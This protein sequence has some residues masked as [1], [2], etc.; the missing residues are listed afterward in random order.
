VRLRGLLGRLLAGLLGRLHRTVGARIACTIGARERVA[1]GAQRRLLAAD[2][3][4]G[5]LG[6]GARHLVDHGARGA[7]GVL[8]VLLCHARRLDLGV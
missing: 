4:L 2:A 6:R 1:H 3:A 7:G 8:H 5:F